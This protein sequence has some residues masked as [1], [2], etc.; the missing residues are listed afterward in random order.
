MAL[1]IH[2]ADNAGGSDTLKWSIDSV[3]TVDIVKRKSLGR[4][5]CVV[6]QKWNVSVWYPF[7]S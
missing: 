6:L 4:F 2:H 1:S 7:D 3:Q 5:D